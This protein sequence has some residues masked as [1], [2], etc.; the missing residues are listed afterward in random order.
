MKKTEISKWSLTLIL[1]IIIASILIMLFFAG[2]PEITHSVD[3]I[4]IILLSFFGSV[5]YVIGAGIIL[6][7]AI[8]LV[9]RY[10]KTKLSHPFRPFGAVPRVTFLTLGLEIMIGAELIITAVQRTL[11]DFWLLM[12]TIGTRG[13]IGL[14]LYLEKRW[15]HEEYEAHKTEIEEKARELAQKRESEKGEPDEDI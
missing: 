10:V 14:I 13:L 5:L 2:T 11:D 7:G 9:L 3:N 6:F 1:A 12:L 15:G 4:V 8:L